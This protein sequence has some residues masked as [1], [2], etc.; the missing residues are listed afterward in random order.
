MYYKLVVEVDAIDTKIPSANGLITL[1]HNA[2]IAKKFKES[3]LKQKWIYFNHNNC[4]QSQEIS[5]D[6]KETQTFKAY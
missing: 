1:I 6:L 5:R 4:L 2:K 3:G